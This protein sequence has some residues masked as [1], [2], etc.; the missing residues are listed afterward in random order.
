MR[1]RKYEEPLVIY[2]YHQTMSEST[3]QKFVLCLESAKNDTFEDF[4]AEYVHPGDPET[5][6]MR[7][8]I[9]MLYIHADIKKMADCEESI[10]LRELFNIQAHEFEELLEV[11]DEM[12]KTALVHFLANHNPEINPDVYLDIQDAMNRTL[13]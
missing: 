2:I 10:Q 1:K 13:I 9:V 6:P 3:R 4:P 11:M 7:L 8:A 12:P 5:L